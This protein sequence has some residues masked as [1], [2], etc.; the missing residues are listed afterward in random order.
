MVGYCVEPNPSRFQTWPGCKCKQR[1]EEGDLRWGSHSEDTHWSG[2]E[3]NTNWYWSHLACVSLRTFSNA[4]LAHGSLAAIPGAVE[5]DLLDELQ[6]A[7]VRAE[8]VRAKSH[9]ASFP[10]LRKKKLCLTRLADAYK[11]AGRGGEGGGEAARAGGEGGGE[12][13]REIGEGS[14]ETARPRREGGGEG[15]REGGEGGGEAA[16][17]RE[18]NRKEKEEDRQRQEGRREGAH[19]KEERG[20]LLEEEDRQRQEGGSEGGSHRGA[21][22]DAAEARGEDRRARRARREKKKDVFLKKRDDAE[23]KRETTSVTAFRTI[24]WTTD[25]H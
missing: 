18:K 10:R 21:H 3:G 11:N 20:S 19:R 4:L 9:D 2:P 25:E 5:H 15:A 17:A 22:A 8:T 12:A 23:P 13:A 6:T 24:S 7:F 1:I 14:R 16:R